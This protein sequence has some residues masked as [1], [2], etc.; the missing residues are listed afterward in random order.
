MNKAL[1]LILALIIRDFQTF[2][3]TFLHNADVPLNLLLFGVA[4]Q[5]VYEA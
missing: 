2:S 5:L 4:S 1:A 3:T